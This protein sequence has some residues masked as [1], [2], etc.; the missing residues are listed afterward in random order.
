MLRPITWKEFSTWDPL[1]RETLKPQRAFDV[2]ARM[3]L[4]DTKEYF[5][6]DP[7]WLNLL[8]NNSG[9][10][11]DCLSSTLAEKLHTQ[12][13]RVYHG[14]RPTCLNSYMMTGLRIHRRSELIE[15]LKAI[16]ASSP[17]LS[18]VNLQKRLAEISGQYDEG[19]SFVTLDDRFMVECAGH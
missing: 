8:A 18:S 17:R 13:L 5:V 10:S 15:E 14:C 7:A 16:I 9:Y 3:K 19:K 12:Q 4:V 6:D 11:V 1:V 2:I